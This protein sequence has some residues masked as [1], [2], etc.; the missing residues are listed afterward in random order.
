M[1]QDRIECS[2]LPDKSGVP[3][4]FLISN[5]GSLRMRASGAKLR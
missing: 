1:R 2:F 3:F 4:A 5:V